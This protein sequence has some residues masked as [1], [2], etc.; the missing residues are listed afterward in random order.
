MSSQN[1]L[2]STATWLSFTIAQRYYDDVHYVW[3]SPIFDGRAGRIGDVTVA[4][5]SSPCEIY[6][7]LQQEAKRA[8]KHSQKM[9]ENRTGILRG[10]GVKLAAGVI[11]KSQSDEISAIVAA[12][13]P[14]DFKPVLLIIPYAKVK[15]L[16][17]EVPVPMRAHPLSV[18]FIIPELP[19]KLF[20]VIELNN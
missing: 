13:Q 20:D 17:Q 16:L 14:C 4:P 6:F 8:D 3:C 18:E 12:A 1:L 9:I 10:A 7:G 2:Y 5:T 11:T 19:R 15:K